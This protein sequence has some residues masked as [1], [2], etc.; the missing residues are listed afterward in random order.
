[1]SLNDLY[2]FQKVCDCWGGFSD[3]KDSLLLLMLAGSQIP[4]NK[5]QGFSELRQGVESLT[6]RHGR[7][8]YLGGLPDGSGVLLSC[9]LD[10]S[11]FFAD[12]SR[13][14]FYLATF[15][16]FDLPQQ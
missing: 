11:S 2:K 15:D 7:I 4:S 10:N 9:Q 6:L 13:K 8:P 3:V 14:D 16:L 12:F 1:M 5:F